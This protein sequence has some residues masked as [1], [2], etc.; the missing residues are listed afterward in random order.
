MS[1]HYNFKDVLGRA[2]RITWRV[3]DL[4]GEGKTLDFTKPFM[5]ESLARVEALSFLNADEKRL[6]NQ[7]RGH[8]YLSIFG[9]VEEFIVP[10][11]LDHARPFINGEDYRARAFLEFVGEEAKHIHL[12]RRFREEFKKGFAT[13]CK[14]IGPAAD[15]GKHILSHQPLS[16]ALAI[17]MIE[18]MTQRHFQESIH[19]DGALDPQFK[20]LLKHHW[21]EEMQHAQLDTLMVENLALG[22][23]QAQI[24][25]AIDG[26]LAI[27]TFLDGGLKQ[28]TE[29]DLDALE[30][31]SGRVLPIEQS[32]ELIAEQ[33]QANRWTYLGTGLTHKNFLETLGQLSP[34][35]R[36]MIEGLSPTFC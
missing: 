23:S 16:V 31:A 28:Q 4:I 2:E 30:A 25:E 12:F 35:K 13:E 8:A 22:M 20:N 27:G 7:V 17:L 32:K 18:W 10:F 34:A 36:E 19:D 14:V 1:Y 15:I 26:F 9:I 21:M 11:V 3:E 29:F 5:P 6:L 33:H 24:D